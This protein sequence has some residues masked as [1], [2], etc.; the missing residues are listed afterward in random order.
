M[1]QCP[2]RSGAFLD[3]A[4]RSPSRLSRDKG[5]PV[6]IPVAITLVQPL[7]RVS[8]RGGPGQ[9]F[10]FQYHQSLGAE[11]DHLA[12]EVAVGGLLQKGLE[13]DQ[14]DTT[15]GTQPSSSASRRSRSAEDGPVG[16]IYLPRAYDRGLTQAGPN[17]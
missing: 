12:Q 14:S 17:D 3:E 6:S 10:N 8:A 13:V 16:S 9:G 11:A 15:P 2:V 4:I 5:L 7:R 1:R